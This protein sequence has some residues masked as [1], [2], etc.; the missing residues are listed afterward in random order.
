M[1]RPTAC[2]SQP[3]RSSL[4]PPISPIL[5]KLPSRGEVVSEPTPFTTIW[6]AL[7]MTSCCWPTTDPV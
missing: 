6:S 3:M 5:A 7:S 4:L 2:S 1:S